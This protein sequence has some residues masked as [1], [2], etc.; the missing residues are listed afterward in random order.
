[1]IF[2]IIIEN[3]CLILNN[4]NKLDSNSLIIF[5]VTYF[6]KTLNAIWSFK[7]TAIPKLNLKICFTSVFYCLS[8]LLNFSLDLIKDET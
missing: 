2:A 5:I 3:I 6:F 8:Y 1:M 7:Q 4:L